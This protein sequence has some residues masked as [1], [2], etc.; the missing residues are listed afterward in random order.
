VKIFSPSA[1]QIGSCVGPTSKLFK[2]KLLPVGD[3]GM[4]SSLHIVFL[5]A[6]IDLLLQVDF[7]KKRKKA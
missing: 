4:N 5:I 6:D 1:V 7:F 3:G 2:P